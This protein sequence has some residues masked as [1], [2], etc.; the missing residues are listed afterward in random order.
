MFHSTAYDGA[1]ERAAINMGLSVFSVSAEAACQKLASKRV[2]TQLLDDWKQGTLKVPGPKYISA[3]PSLPSEAVVPELVVC[4][5][6][7]G[8]L[9]IPV[10][11]RQ[12][13]LTDPVRS[14]EWK[15][16]LNA[17]DKSHGVVAP[18][19][20]PENVTMPSTN[21][22]NG[23]D[24]VSDTGASTWSQ[25]FTGE[26]RTLQDL[27]GQ[28]QVCASFALNGSG[29]LVFKV[30]EGPKLFICACTA[31]EF[32][33]SEPLLCHGAGTWLLDNK[34]KK[35]VQDRLGKP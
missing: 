7:D 3:V 12:K 9:H 10:D 15:K 17:F 24:G 18:P 34:A 1:L 4:K 27:E 30:V 11:I 20:K 13:Y 19:P 21:G 31:G 26:P 14:A 32:S 29:S 8:T 6:V 23:N 2:K 28:H 35:A 16:L 22:S 33:A 5:Q 25:I